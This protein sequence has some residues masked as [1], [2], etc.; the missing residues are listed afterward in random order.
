[1]PVNALEVGLDSFGEVATDGGRTLDD[2]EA[3]RLL[4]EEARLA[5]AAGIDEGSPTATP[6]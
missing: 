4:V 1:M 3:V 2:A 5:E 6:K